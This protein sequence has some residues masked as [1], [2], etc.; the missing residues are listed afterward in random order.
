M[1][2][3]DLKALIGKEVFLDGTGN[4]RVRGGPTHILP[5]VITG[6]GRV[7]V[8]IEINSRP[9]TKL[10]FNL[11]YGSSKKPHL[12]DEFN[13]GYDL[14]ISEQDVKDRKESLRLSRLIA[15]RYKYPEGFAG[16]DLDDV[17]AIADILG[18]K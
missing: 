18:I 11:S 14:Y 12:N 13:G 9:E 3:T 2:L 5:A 7:N 15:N 8:R 17:K 16:L 10:R 6:V 4:N 1:T